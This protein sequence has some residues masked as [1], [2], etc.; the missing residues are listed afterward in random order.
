MRPYADASPLEKEIHELERQAFQVQTAVTKF[1]RMVDKLGTNQDTR[2]LRSKLSASKNAVQ[3]QAKEVMDR[4][5]GL[6]QKKED[7]PKR[8][9]DRLNR[10]GQNF[11]AVLEDFQQALKRCND[12]EVV[13][14]RSPSAALAEENDAQ[15]AMEREALLQEQRRQE[16]LVLDN[17]VAHNE[18]L[19]EERDQDINAVIRDIGELH[20]MFQDVATL[21]HDQGT[22]LDDIETNITHAA[23]RVDAANTELGMANKHQKS[24]T[25]K[26]I[27]LA[28]ALAIVIALVLM[29]VMLR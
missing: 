15:A 18:S 8:Q 29:A 3:V 10:A 7:L 21:V 17:M 27:C 16:A 14:P 24:A 6:N 22:M 28:V 26:R 9:K 1:K 25:S 12:A 20:E 5:V 19:I 13:S 2:D 4:M 11:T 23:D